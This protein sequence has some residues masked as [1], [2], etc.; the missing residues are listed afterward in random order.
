MACLEARAKDE[1]DQARQAVA[2]AL[3]KL[4]A[5]QAR[6]VQF[7][8]ML[9]PLKDATGSLSPGLLKLTEARLRRA[10][11]REGAAL[12]PEKETEA[13][14]RA[15]LHKRKLVGYRL[16][17]EVREAPS[18]GLKLAV[19]GLRYPGKQLLGSISVQG[20]GAEPGDILAALAPS[21]IEEAASSFKWK[22]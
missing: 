4:R 1:D 18:N 22:P 20:T 2:S 5:L 15:V 9:V 3:G 7:Y 17:I 14:A 13:E 12:A 19:L 11:R 16:I 10:L 6:P 21:A 8:V